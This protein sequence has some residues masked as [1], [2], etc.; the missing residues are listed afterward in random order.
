MPQAAVL[1]AKV[2]NRIKAAWREEVCLIDDEKCVPI[3]HPVPNEKR[4][5]NAFSILQGVA[6]RGKIEVFINVL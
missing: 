1:V 4:V 3:I 2:A 6:N 5:K